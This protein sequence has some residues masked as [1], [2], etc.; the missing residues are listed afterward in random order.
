MDWSAKKCIPCEGG[1]MP[2]SSDK[3]QEYLLAIPGWRVN[4]DY[5]KINR[6][7][8]LKDFIAALKFINQIGEIAETEGHHP[9]I[10]LFSWNHVKVILFTH[11]IGGLSDNDFIMA[12]KINQLWHSQ[13]NASA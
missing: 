11:A 1:V 3:V 13:P 12:A 2:H 8:I 4:D 5:K 7:F 9:N 10:E 6:E